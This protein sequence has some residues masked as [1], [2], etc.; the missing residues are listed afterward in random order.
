MLLAAI[1]GDYHLFECDLSH[2]LYL[3]NPQ[4]KFPR[5]HRDLAIGM[6][7]GILNFALLGMTVQSAYLSIRD[8]NLQAWLNVQDLY[9]Y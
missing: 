9:G 4:S 8:L 5:G 3:G 1:N 6:Y 2:L 7:S